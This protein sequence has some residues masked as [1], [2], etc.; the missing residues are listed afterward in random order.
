MNKKKIKILVSQS[1]KN[2]TIDKSSVNRIA[3]LLS[4]SD[5]KQYLR[6]LKSYESKKNIIIT[7]PFLG[8][9]KKTFEKLFPNKMIVYKK[10]PSLMVGIK[11]IDNDTVYEFDLKNTLDN[12]ISHIKQNYD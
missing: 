8:S 6:Q 2:N 12:I 5:L 7:L 1:Y 4:R 3:A 9:D 11:I 10:D